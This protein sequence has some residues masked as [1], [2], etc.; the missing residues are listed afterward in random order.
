MGRD[1]QGRACR[2]ATLIGLVVA[3]LGSPPVARADDIGGD[4]G[5]VQGEIRLTGSETASL[6]ATSGPNGDGHIYEVRPQCDDDLGGQALCAGTQPCVADDGATGIAMDLFR[7][8]VLYGETCLSE[9][10]AGGLSV[11]TPAMVVREF[12]RLAWP[13]SPLSIEPPGQRT[14]VNLPTYFFTDNRQP[15]TQT[16]Q[17]IGQAVE[18]EATP[19]SYVYRFDSSDALETTSAGGPYPRGDV[20]HTYLYQGS[21]SPSLDTVYSG[22]YRVNGGRWIDIPD[23]VT[24]AG[25]SSTLEIVEVRPTLVSPSRP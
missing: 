14:A 16:V 20:T 5:S 13:E 2:L 15:S 23:T 3:L 25:T 21:A 22:R 12:R 17:I 7:D 9:S 24:V 8:G 1:R 6:F 18:I 10:Q 11:I 19:A 4:L